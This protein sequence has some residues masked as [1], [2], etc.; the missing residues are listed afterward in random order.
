[1]PNLPHPKSPGLAPSNL[2]RQ[3]NRFVGRERLT[4][5][6]RARLLRDDVRL[7]TLTGAGGT[8]KTRLALQV[9]SSLQ[10]DF[11]DG[12]Y[13]VSLAP[14]ADPDLV[15]STIAQ[16][17]GVKETGERS[18]TDAVTAAL[19]AKRILLV[20]DN[21]EHL[22]PAAPSVAS[23]LSACPRVNVLATSRAAL[24]LY[25]EHELPVPP[26][27]LPDH[28]AIPTAEHAGAFEAVRLFVERAQA[29][30]PAFG[31][32]D[33]NAPSI[34]E[35]CRRLDGLPLAIE[36]AAARLR[37]LPL[38]AL[39]ER[40]E[41]R[42][43]LL[44]GGPRDLPARQQTLRNTI[45]WSY[46]LLSPDEQ[47]LF[48]RLAVFRGCTLDAL[49]AVCCAPGPANHATSVALEPLALE[50]LDGATSL[51]EK[52]LLR[53]EEAEDGQPWYVMLE[54]VHE[55]ALERLAASPEADPIHRRHVLHQLTLAEAA[56]ARLTGP[57]QAAWLARLEREHDNLR[58]AIR[59]SVGR[60]HGQA[61][62]RLVLALWW[63]WATHGHLNEG[64]QLMA[65]VL[66]RFRPRDPSHRLIAL[67]AR[68]LQA[69]GYLAEFQGDLPAAR[70]Q[71]AEA[72][73]LFR[74]L[75]DQAGVE[76][77][78][79]ALGQVAMLEG[80]YATARTLIEEARSRAEARD[81]RIAV[82]VTLWSLADIVHHQGDFATARTLIEQAVAVKRE[83]AGPREVAL[84]IL[85][86][87]V[88]LEAQGDYATARQLCEESLEECRQ[89]SDWRVLGF[90]LARLGGI[91]TVQ[92]DLGKAREA[93]VESLGILDQLG[94]LGGLAFVVDGFAVLASCQAQPRRAL[95]L[96]GAATALRASIAEPRAQ[97]TAA[98]YDAR[99]DAARQTLGEV[100]SADAWQSG[101]RMARAEAI[102]DALAEEAATA[103]TDSEVNASS[104]KRSPTRQP[105]AAM[106]PATNGARHH[107]DRS[108]RPS[109]GHDAIG[110]ALS[111]REREVA[112]CIA[113]GYTNRQIADALV[114]TPGTVANHVKHIL[115]RL[116]YSNRAQVAVW[117]TEQKLRP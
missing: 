12:V 116:G 11:A 10:S 73:R 20:L 81:D 97:V 3:S 69:A 113:R 90:V 40:M 85:H 55:Y 24:R 9:A 47:T 43:P 42:L 75:D 89:A 68:T 15:P 86:L 102:A 46:D 25:G 52:S 67:R 62:S 91:L 53:Q 114:I 16:A 66:D 37:S 30:Q 2:P 104:K 65:G 17:L 31:L 61:A 103:Q 21:V 88:L 64:R 57:D 32:D 79:G 49:Q 13:F 6:A 105:V 108:R 99:L 96:A 112:L 77:V 107:G 72:L 92:G 51:V 56:E 4:E 54:T 74:G 117:A 19:H 82:S 76:S 80:D 27:T 60:G 87:S 84:H 109:G 28:R 115:D 39:Q 34:I 101:R 41:R 23:L 29:V 22:L 58:A 36:L 50:P 7:L 48:R 100:A 78:L 111:D 71:H 95:R 93:L 26:L 63:F 14:V 35:I 45:A 94:D 98:G 70:S 110:P 8:G 18:V 83:V 5:A 1:M 106:A 44:T 33:A 59:W 38:R